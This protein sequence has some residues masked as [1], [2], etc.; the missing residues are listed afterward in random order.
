ML[1]HA[2]TFLL[3]INLVL[4]TVHCQMDMG[5]MGTTKMAAPQVAP[6]PAVAMNALMQSTDD[7]MMAVPACGSIDVYF[8]R[9]MIA[10]HQGA[11]W[12]AQW[13][14][15]HGKLSDL[16]NTSSSI[17]VDQSQEII[18]LQNILATL[19]F[20]ADCMPSPSP[21]MDMRAAAN[22]PAT[23]DSPGIAEMGQAMTVPMSPSPGMPEDGADAT[24]AET[25]RT[26]HMAAIQMAGV[27]IQHGSN[28]ELIQLAETIVGEQ[29]TE[30][31][32]FNRILAGMAAAI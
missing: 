23:A 28:P 16:L 9:T 12:M 2:Q 17:I 24:F 11:I 22:G 5:V 25:M 32:Q 13:Y 29:T 27:E 31:G 20:P 10:H 3:C 30:I 8:A 21:S 14:L 15:Q 19:P 1:Q 4:A 18:Q 26:H 7:A 6:S